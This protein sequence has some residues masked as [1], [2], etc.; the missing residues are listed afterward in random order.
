MPV[1]GPPEASPVHH[2][3]H[4][5]HAEPRI[6]TLRSVISHTLSHQSDIWSFSL[7]ASALTS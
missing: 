2:A 6:V 4:L 5:L 7:R 1:G 3:L